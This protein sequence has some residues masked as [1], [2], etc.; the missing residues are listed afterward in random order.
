ML[1]TQLSHWFVPSCPARKE[2]LLHTPKT[3]AHLFVWLQGYR[4]KLP[5]KL[6]CLQGEEVLLS[7]TGLRLIW[8]W[9][10]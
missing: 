8:F 5:F 2:S 3:R 4:G 1:S 6:I 10:H 9:L 7:R